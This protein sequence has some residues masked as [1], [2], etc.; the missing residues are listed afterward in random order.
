[1][2]AIRV[3]SILK[4]GPLTDAEYEVVKEHARIGS[5]I[6]KNIEGAAEI[7]EIVLHHHERWDG[8]GYPDGLKCGRGAPRSSRIWPWR[9]AFN[10]MCSRRPYR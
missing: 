8:R 4:A 2:W 1:M 7:A 9:R 5:G 6:I 10:A 3:P